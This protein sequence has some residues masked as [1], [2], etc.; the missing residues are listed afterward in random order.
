VATGPY[1][2]AEVTYEPGVGLIA[3]G[4]PIQVAIGSGSG[5]LTE[6]DGGDAFSS[7]ADI[8]DGGSA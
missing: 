3:R 5:S 2:N 8:I 7:S 1:F 6:V 4:L